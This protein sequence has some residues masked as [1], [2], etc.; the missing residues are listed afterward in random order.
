[1]GYLFICTHQNQISDMNYL[2]SKLW[3]PF[4]LIAILLILYLIWGLDETR[5]SGIVAWIVSLLVL[6]LIFFNTWI[7]FQEIKKQKAREMELQKLNG[8][9]I[10]ATQ[11]KSRWK[12]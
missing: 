2:N 12:R 10:E 5:V 7:L 6:A 4:Y 9:H 3:G 11:K 1:M 8:K